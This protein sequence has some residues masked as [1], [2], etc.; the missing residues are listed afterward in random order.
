M[1]DWGE[2]YVTDINYTSGFYRELS[3]VWLAT[4]ATLL[5]F[6][7]PPIGQPYTY[8]ELGCGTGFGINLLAAANPQ[9]RF[10]GF[11]F[12]PAHTAHARRLAEAAGSGNVEFHEASFQS[13][14]AAG[15]WPTFDFLALHGVYSWV[16]RDNQLALQAFI[17]RF[18]K[19]GGL[20]YISYNCG[21]GW[22]SMVPVQRML[23]LYADK[24]P[25]RSDVQGRE[26]L[27]F[28]QRLREGGAAFFGVHGDL[29]WWLDLAANA[30]S[31]YI[32]HEFLNRDWTAVDF[33]SMAEDCA[34]AKL[35]YL[36]SANL[37]EN[38]DALSVPASL[39]PVLAAEDDPLLRQ[40]ILDFATNKVFRRDIYQ[41][42]LSPLT[43]QERLEAVKRI[44]LAPLQIPGPD[45]I[46]F[47]TPVGEA[48]GQADVYGP[49]L[50]ALGKGEM[51][52]EA[53]AARPEMVGKNLAD[54]IEVALLL[55]DGGYAHPLPGDTQ[56]VTA[57]SFNRAVCEAM[58]NGHGYEFLAAPG[59]GGGIPASFTDMLAVLALTDEPGLDRE[60][61]VDAAWRLLEQNNRRLVKNG[62][63]LDS[64]QAS[65]AE[66]QSIHAAFQSGKGD[67]W[68]RLGVLPAQSP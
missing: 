33:A 23:R 62:V 6:R 20:A 64:K 57:Q 27:G 63:M 25:A 44:R 2:G 60:G 35:A 65:Q 16:S 59:L 28:V 42:G 32:P 48:S 47:K 58:L 61:F 37:L 19:P 17:R 24:H 41:K 67:G 11:D 66:L 56:A 36:G 31:H 39:Q 30:D 22:A 38:L 21:V 9:G 55:I 29:P 54:L 15:D 12:N 5:G 34:H 1:A 52:L 14:A 10:W 51:S 8:A 46:R 53:V 68:R 50:T 40:A 45:E 43:P 18:L 26:A 13:M 49:L 4:A 7:A 3:P